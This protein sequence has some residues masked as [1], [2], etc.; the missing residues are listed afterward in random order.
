M[1]NFIELL[2]TCIPMQ[3]HIHNNKKSDMFACEIGV[4]QGEHL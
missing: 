4:R 1:G 2:K 3:D